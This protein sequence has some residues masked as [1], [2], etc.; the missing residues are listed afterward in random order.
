MVNFTNGLLEGEDIISQ[1][2]SSFLKV[3][4]NKINLKSLVISGERSQSWNRP[5]V[6]WDHVETS[7]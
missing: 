5:I 2:L 7:P 6:K 3:L 4:F 1:F